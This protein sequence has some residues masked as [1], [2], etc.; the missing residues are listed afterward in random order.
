[1]AEFN[2]LADI[3]AR[4]NARL[5]QTKRIN[6]DRDA[7]FAL[8]PEV[9]TGFV[10]AF[11][12]SCRWLNE[13]SHTIE[14]ECEQPDPNALRI[15]RIVNDIACPALDFILDMAVPRIICRDQWNQRE[16][17]SIGFALSGS[18]AILVSGRSGIILSEF[19]GNMIRQ[20]TR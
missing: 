3:L 13:R 7:L 2:M 19:V 14:L 20:I 16:Q 18:R 8:I 10:T 5:E 1:M 15:R 6:A 4:E 9:W 12:D 17:S 11:R